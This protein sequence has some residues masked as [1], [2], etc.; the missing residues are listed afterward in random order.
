MLQGEEAVRL[1]RSAVEAEVSGRPAP[2]IP[3]TGAFSDSAGAFVTLDTFPAG[4]LRGCIGIPMPVMPLGQ[5]IVEA[6]GSACNDP[7]FPRLSPGELGGVTVEVTVLSRP[8]A[9]RADTPEGI[10][11]SIVIGRDGLIL[12]FMGRRGLFLPQVPVEQGWDKEEYLDHLCMKAGLPPGTWRREGAR[13]ET[14]TGEAW[15]ETT[16]RGDIV[17]REDIGHRDRG[18]RQGPRRR[19]AQVHRGRDLRREDSIRREH[20]AGRGQ[21]DRA[22]D[23]RRHAA[24]V[25]RSACAS[26]RPRDDREGG[27]RNR[28]PRSRPRGGD[29]RV[30]HAQHRAAR[31]RR[32]HVQGEEGGRGQEGSHRLRPVRGGHCRRQRRDAGPHGRGVQAVHGIDHGEHPPGRRRGDDPGGK[33]R[34]RHRQAHERPRRGRPPDI[35]GRGAVLQ[36]PPEEPPRRGGVEGHIQAGRELPRIQHKH[37]PSDHARGPGHGEGRRL[38]HRMH[39]ASHHF[40]R[41]PQPRRRVQGEPP[42]EGRP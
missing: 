25:R 8:E 21:E 11:E 28:H 17:R 36:G 1:A 27:L 41:R 29:L 12:S 5:A 19:G 26:P 39:H 15:R 35:E 38:L 6:A 3:G 14:F 23:Q 30:R 18:V 42:A 9:I 4:E 33:G 34:A 2:A 31:H 10:L 7:R 22:G 16:P 32:P 37:L 20:G 13:I 40:R 24:R